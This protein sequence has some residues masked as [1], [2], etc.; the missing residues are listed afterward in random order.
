MRALTLLI[1][2]DRLAGIVLTVRGVTDTGTQWTGEGT[3]E[4]DDL[5][6]S[7]ETIGRW[8]NVRVIEHHLPAL[9]HLPKV[10]TREKAGHWQDVNPC[11]KPRIQC[12]AAPPMCMRPRAKLRRWPSL[13]ERRA[14][15]GAR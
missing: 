4:T 15:W 2:D 9:L 13:K 1:L 10:N 14:S 3:T 8:E 11:I 12:I 5:G 7:Y 6:T